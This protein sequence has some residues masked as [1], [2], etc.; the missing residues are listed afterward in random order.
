M[1]VVCSADRSE[2]KNGEMFVRSLSVGRWCPCLRFTLE[3]RHSW[4]QRCILSTTH[5]TTWH[6]VTGTRLLSGDVTRSNRPLHKP[7]E[8]PQI[9]Q[10]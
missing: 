4:T 6:H 1:R 7:T 3:L 5:T 10:R 9:S 2:R 8:R